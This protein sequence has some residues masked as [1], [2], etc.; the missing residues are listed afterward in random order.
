MTAENTYKI[1]ADDLGNVMGIVGDSED[2]RMIGETVYH[3]VNFP[4]DDAICIVKVNG[5]YQFY[6]KEMCIRDRALASPLS[7]SMEV[8]PMRSMLIA[9]GHYR[10]EWTV[11]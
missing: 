2:E 1:T 4:K 6:V 10:Q 9:V 7:M 5:T 11:F 3:F 8:D